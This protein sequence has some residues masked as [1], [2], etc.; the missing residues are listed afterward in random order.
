MKRVHYAVVGCGVCLLAR[1]L[2]RQSE[3]GLREQPQEGS[4]SVAQRARRI[5]VPTATA[6]AAVAVFTRVSHGKSLRYTFVPT[7][8][9]SWGLYMFTFRRRMPNPQRVVPLYLLA[10]GWQFVHFIEEYQTGFYYRWPTEI[11]DAEP[12]GDKEFVTIN[13]VSYTAF[14]ASGIAL[15][16]RVPEL[17]LPAIFFAVM[18]VMVNGI[19]HPIYSL[20]VRGYFPGLLSSLADLVLGPMLLRQLFRF[21][22]IAPRD[23]DSNSQ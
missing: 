18:G 14:V 1:V 11:F 21:E 16:F 22:S 9:A 15:M 3:R 10:L 13:V 7:M 23:G 12:Y 2:V 19:Q 4:P 20:M 17:S 5:A 6:I 8:V